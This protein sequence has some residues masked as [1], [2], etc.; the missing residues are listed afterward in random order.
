MGDA[1]RLYGYT[2][3]RPPSKFFAPGTMVWV[4]NKKPF[5]AGVICTEAS[6]LGKAFRPVA[7]ETASMQ[8]KKVTDRSFSIDGDYL[9]LL[10]A[11]ARFS[12]VSEV[13]VRLERPMLYEVIDTD[14]IKHSKDRTANCRRAISLRRN[15]GYQVTM[16]ASALQADVT[17]TVSWSY[18]VGAGV[19]HSQE[20]LAALALELGADNAQVHEHSITAKGLFWGIKDDAFLAQM[21]EPHMILDVGRHPRL[22]EPQQWRI[23]S[24]I[25][26][27]PDDP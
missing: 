19:G 17:Y 4:R 21:S 9:A 7:S 26:D 16:I 3:I 12:H 1:M 5:S 6:S 23:V 27:A 24:T 10:R 15:A 14:I 22:M 20:T 11:D 18:E 25:P 13:T 8:L 2:E